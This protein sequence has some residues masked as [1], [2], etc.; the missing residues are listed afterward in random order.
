MNAFAHLAEQKILEAIANG[1]F[2]NLPG[3]GRPLN[4]EDDSNIPASLRL[5]FKILKNANVLPEEMQLKKDILALQEQLRDAP[6]A[7]AQALRRQL[8][9]LETRFHL[10]MER[11]RRCLRNPAFRHA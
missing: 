9:E 7:E 3:H 1:E 6:H 10:L 8:R 5:G 2:D 4:W 11:H